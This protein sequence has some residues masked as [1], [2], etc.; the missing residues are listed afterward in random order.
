[1]FCQ[2]EPMEASPPIPHSLIQRLGRIEA[3]PQEMHAIS[4]SC[5]CSSQTRRTSL[6]LTK[7]HTIYMQHDLYSPFASGFANSS[8][9]LIM[10]PC[11]RDFSRKPFGK[12]V[13]STHRFLRSVRIQLL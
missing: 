2:L 11:R 10:S 13:S 8:G 1:M 5:S 12:M 3:A 9:N 7:V 6:Q 4:L